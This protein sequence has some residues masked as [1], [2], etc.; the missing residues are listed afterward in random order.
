MKYSAI[1]TST[2]HYTEKMRS[3]TYAERVRNN[4][5]RIIVELK[6]T[7]IQDI[8]LVFGCD[9]YKFTKGFPDETVFLID[10]DSHTPH[11][12]LEMTRAAIDHLDTTDSRTFI[13]PVEYFHIHEEMLR[14]FMGIKADIV[15]PKQAGAAAYPVLLS[16][17]AI[18][19][20][21][22]YNG[23]KG[24]RGAWEGLIQIGCLSVAEGTIDE[25]RYRVKEKARSYQKV[26]NWI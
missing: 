8:V 21:H 11:P 1:L 25:G 22:L 9:S 14:E 23:S 5:K 2:G 19:W 3:G 10:C 7:G 16:S 26:I 15:L 6:E 4:I 24:L 20:C 13:I 18:R 17:T 12:M